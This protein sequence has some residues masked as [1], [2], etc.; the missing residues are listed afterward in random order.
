MMLWGLPQGDK[1]LT[2]IK[3]MLRQK[4]KKM[5]WVTYDNIDAIQ[6]AYHFTV[7]S[8]LNICA[9]FSQ[10]TSACWEKN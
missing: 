1:P 7:R 5:F 3:S 4:K 8:I 9:L 6:K 2:S 10:Q